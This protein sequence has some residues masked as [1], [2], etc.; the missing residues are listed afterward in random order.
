[1]TT[2]AILIKTDPAL[3]YYQLDALLSIFLY[4]KC[5]VKM[6]CG[7]GKSII[8]TNVIIHG[9]KELNVIVFPSLALIMQYSMDYLLNE[10]NVTH[11][12]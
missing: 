12:N 3:R 10:S 2:K 11:L 4:A 5:L 8:I 9:K 6:F 7:V 1:M